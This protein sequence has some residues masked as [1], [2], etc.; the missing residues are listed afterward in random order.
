V[1]RVK[2]SEGHRIELEA[3]R[4]KARMRCKIM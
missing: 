2:Y 1:Q 3:S 4:H